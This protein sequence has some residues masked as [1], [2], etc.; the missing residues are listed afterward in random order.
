MTCQTASVPI[1]AASLSKVAALIGQRARCPCGRY[2]DSQPIGDRQLTSV[3]PRLC[4]SST[5]SAMMATKTASTPSA[6]P[7]FLMAVG[8]VMNR[9]SISTR[10]DSP[11][12]AGTFRSVKIPPTWG[13]FSAGSTPEA[14][15]MPTKSAPAAP[16]SAQMCST[17]QAP[18]ATAER[19]ATVA[20]VSRKATTT[21]SLSAR[22]NSPFLPGSTPPVGSVETTKPPLAG[23]VAIAGQG[24]EMSNARGAPDTSGAVTWVTC[25]STLP[26]GHRTVAVVWRTGSNG[27]ATHSSRPTNPATTAINRGVRCDR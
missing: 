8:A 4:R 15:G 24:M 3:L 13:F 19:G 18:A 6:I 23:R 14:P 11:G 26:C 27:T 16:A 25:P 5:D 20:T 10:A 7:S 22:T 21:T 1:T 12:C 2:R 9:V 17:L